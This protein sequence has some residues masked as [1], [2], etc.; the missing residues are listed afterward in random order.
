MK[1]RLLLFFLVLSIAFPVLSNTLI[2]SRKSGTITSIYKISPKEALRV[3]KT[4]SLNQPELLLH[5]LIDVYPS[6]SVYTKHL[7]PGHYVKSRIVKNKQVFEY[8]YVPDFDVQI[9]NNNTDLC[10]R[11][12]DLHGN[13]ISDAKVSVGLC[14]LKYDKK[15]NCFI[16][17]K[18]NKK[19]F[20][21]VV[22]GENTAYYELRRIVNNSWIKRAYVKTFYSVPLGYVWIPV[23]MI[24]KLPVD[25][26]KSIIYGYKTG[27]VSQFNYF[28]RNLFNHNNNS[29]YKG[30]MVFNKPQYLPH[31][32]VKLKAF[33]VRK[34]GIPFNKNLIAYIYNGRKE[35]KIS[36]VKPYRPGAYSLNF[37]LSDSLE[38]RLDQYYQV[39]LKL[40]DKTI[41]S[42]TFKYEDY[43]LNPVNLL[44]SS[45]AEQY[46]NQLFKLH[47]KAT[48]DN[49][50]NIQDA[51]VQVSLVLDQMKE[52]EDNYLFVPKVFWSDK[53]NLQPKGETEIIIPDSIFPKANFNYKAN[54]QL[55]TSDNRILN[56]SLSVAYF[57]KD[58]KYVFELIK[59]SLKVR[60][61][62]N[63]KDSV[64]LTKLVAIDN[65]ENETTLGNFK[66]P[67][68]CK[69]NT[70]YASYEVESS[71]DID[72]FDFHDYS[73][74]IN[75]VATRTA[76][77]LLINLQNPRNLNVVYNIYKHN[78]EIL[79]G[80]G[81]SLYFKQFQKSKQNFYITL[82]YLWGGEVKSQTYTA[83]LRDKNLN[84]KMEK[85]NLV[86]PG[87]KSNLTVNVTD[88]TGK[89]VENVDVTAFSLTDKFQY[90]PP[91]VPYLGKRMPDK[92]LINNFKIDLPDVNSANRLLNT[93]QLKTYESLDT[94]EYY[95]F[96]YPENGFYR[97]DYRMYD[98]ITQFAPFVFD[99]N[100]NMKKIQVIYVDN[101]PVYFAWSDNNQPFSFAVSD[102]VPHQ[103]KLRLK[104]QTIV[105]PNVSFIKGYKT[106]LSLRSDM[107]S[108]Y[109]S[110]IKNQDELTANERKQLRPYIFPFIN[111]R[112]DALKYLR[113]KDH[114]EWLHSDTYWGYQYAGP[115]L[116]PVEAGIW[117]DYQHEFET[118][119][120]Y[121]Y[122]IKDKVVKM[123]WI[124]DKMYP[125]NHLTEV[126]YE[127]NIED[128]VLTKKIL[129]QVY[130]DYK[131]N[132]LYSLAG[133]SN[134][135]NNE[136]SNASLELHLDGLKISNKPLFAV[137]INMED[138]NAV[139]VYKGDITK[140]YDVIPGNYKIV[141]YFKR[142]N[143]W[144]SNRFQLQKSGQTYIKLKFP[145]I[146]LNDSMSVEYKRIIEDVL[147]NRKKDSS[148]WQ[149][150][151]KINSSLSSYQDEGYW[152]EGKV[153]ENSRGEPIMGASVV[154]PGTNYGTITD[155][156]GNFRLKLPQ[157][158]D[159]INVSYLGFNTERVKLESNTFIHVNMKE[160]LHH[161]DEVVVVGYGVQK[162]S[163]L[164][165]SVTSSVLQ[166]SVPGVIAASSIKIRGVGSIA[167]TNS[168]IYVVDGK[169]WDGDVT[170]IDQLNVEAIEVLKN[171]TASAL[172]GAQAANGVVLV[173]TKG[174]AYKT[175]L[176]K[177]GKGAD[178]DEAFVS[179]LSNANSI[180][181]HFSDYGFWEPRLKTDKLGNA[182]FQVEFP[183][184]ITKWNIHV[185][186]MNDKLQSGVRTAS[187]K[188][189][190]PLMAQILAPDFLVK[191]DSC[192]LI[193][194][195]LNYFPDSAMV[196]TEFDLNGE[197]KVFPE[198]ICKDAIID[199][200]NVVAND[201]S[202]KVK[203]MLRNRAGYIDGE[204][205]KIGLESAGIDEVYGNFVV[206]DK[207]STYKP[208]F[209]KNGSQATIYASAG[210]SDFI[211]K[212][213]ADL[214]NYKYDCNEQLAS[215]LIARLSERKIAQDK[216]L[217][218]KSDAD[219]KK[220]ISKLLK[221]QKS[222]GLWG[223][224]PGSNVNYSFSVHIMT[225]LSEAKNQG[226]IVDIDET[227]LA[228]N[229]VTYLEQS[230]HENIDTDLA[231][232][233][234]LQ[235]FHC[236][237]DFK[238]YLNELDMVKN[239]SLNNKL[240]MI[241]LRQFNHLP[242]D[243]TVLKSFEH[244]DALGNIFYR[245]KVE[246]GNDIFD[247]DV[248]NTLIAYR[249]IREQNIQDTLL[250][251][252]RN[253][254]IDVRKEFKYQNTYQ[255]A[256]IIETILPD[257]TN[258]VGSEKV[259]LKISGSENLV[260][261]KFPFIMP[262]KPDADVILT[263]LGENQLYIS[264]YQ[265]YLN[266]KPAVKTN[267][268]FEITTHFDNDENHLEAG[269][270]V[271]LLV[272]LNV[273]RDAGYVMITVPIPGSCTYESS[274]NINL[275]KDS[276]REYF[277]NITNI[278]CE[279]LKEGKYTYEINLIPRFSGS[280]CLNPAKVEL[281]YFPSNNA[282]EG[283]KR[284]LIN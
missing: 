238:T 200:I 186:A 39:S 166:G 264:T 78:H 20:L 61:L 267:D 10:I 279:N 174:N 231:V 133:N 146:L 72:W 144:V 44:V 152:V 87:Q 126:F 127:K 36:E 271:R 25:A 26:T 208:E 282:H 48:N 77:S 171:E 106:V 257:I 268:N 32:T 66:T 4:E 175:E 260:V 227:E 154:V 49:D 270:P 40:K 219:I 128:T 58:K 8:L 102:S 69:L 129:D 240:T 149:N 163:M 132:Q 65:F 42:S 246:S 64:V 179:S 194:K 54:I 45:A 145:E 97:F 88:F 71:N 1:I 162:K 85:P 119:T 251:K 33:I 17:R 213:I 95:K 250:Q 139:K 75:C 216:K 62:V 191:N 3:N 283:I 19:G 284:V 233:K 184:D 143:Y 68:V 254:L 23:R 125:Y 244:K 24:C 55:N 115:V 172:Y 70:F 169:I 112:N 242:Y 241:E 111:D 73:P 273:K 93:N 134:F 38:L 86:Y 43:I 256:Q 94:I 182:Q 16:Q 104:N 222:T 56:K 136:S 155:L 14:N 142:G 234:I 67:F 218:Y 140:I 90:T 252:I 2:Q 223:W 83:I 92:E 82:R 11:V 47:V 63:G 278:Y 274:K 247:N 183:D 81:K 196:T 9:M 177:I 221:N 135:M 89:P 230:K 220:L 277:K 185:L 151:W 210:Y 243:T 226:F 148:S 181:T 108:V 117:N 18:S 280:Y 96:R 281:M 138:V 118:E 192:S 123:K 253:Y 201:D 209:N 29:Q 84:I 114:Y 21:K 121:V 205:R 41:W 6:D 203:Y 150:V 91:A 173:T 263:K 113:S 199:T 211:E 157:N 52:Y 165:G 37:Y 13:I 122:D 28:F 27:V 190:K 255:I 188:S 265:H 245:D 105:I 193:G 159:E 107:S 22:V 237:V 206:L 110:S 60:Y 232:L 51:R 167:E 276:Y 79:R 272:D 80:S 130:E 207:D 248:Q 153:V 249:V 187:I 178:F 224:W 229:L 30:Y 53:V 235:L 197:N 160:S 131:D 189:Y 57:Y 198:R 228:R 100:G 59:D 74:E 31:D 217:E 46:K 266:S 180:R 124:G 258:N 161:L 116:A 50:L 262:I 204:Q 147:L 12:Y 202:M 34:S 164:T 212:D 195:V 156:A 103:V 5:T 109:Y 239:K 259:K 275:N 269:K 76:D 168:P 7:E 176:A 99:I 170:S 214:V 137:L 15:T 35:I 225:A 261:D 215:K 120:G 141:F 158:R 98:R 101:K 236:A